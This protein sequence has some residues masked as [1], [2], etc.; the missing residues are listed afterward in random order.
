MKIHHLQAAVALVIASLQPQPK[1]AACQ[2]MIVERVYE[3]GARVNKRDI[4]ELTEAL[5]Q[6]TEELRSGRAELAR[7]ADSDFN[8]AI[9]VGEEIKNQ[10]IHVAGIAESFVLMLPEKEIVL[11]YDKDSVEFAFVKAIKMLSIA[12]KNYLNLIDQVTRTTEVRKSGVDF[13]A[14]RQ[15]LMTGNKAAEDFHASAP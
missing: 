9:N 2:P 1:A 12:T 7:Y 8:A 11:S 10:A 6:V 5:N 4:K 13:A 15:L 3:M 14:M